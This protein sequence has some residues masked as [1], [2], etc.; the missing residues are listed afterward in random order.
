[1][2]MHIVCNLDI[3]M[4]TSNNK[5]SELNMYHHRNQLTCHLCSFFVTVRATLVIDPRARADD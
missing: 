5:I 3:V 2:E 1:M 4:K